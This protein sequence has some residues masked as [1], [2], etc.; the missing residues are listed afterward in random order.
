MTAFDETNFISAFL[1][2]Y[3]QQTEDYDISLVFDKY[4]EEIIIQDNRTDEIF[5]HYFPNEPEYDEDML[6]TKLYEIAEA[7]IIDTCESEADTDI[8]DDDLN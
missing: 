6:F 5:K 1:E 2:Y 4:F 7:T 3:N 8:D